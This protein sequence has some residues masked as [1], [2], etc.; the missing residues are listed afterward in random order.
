M[1]WAASSSASEEFSRTTLH[2]TAQ[3]Q[4]VAE[5]QRWT[6]KEREALVR[7]V[8]AGLGSVEFCRVL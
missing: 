1:V 2:M 3:T 5:I 6:E 8:A 7:S 4:T